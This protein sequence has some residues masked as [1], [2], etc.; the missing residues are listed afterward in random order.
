MT[1]VLLPSLRIALRLPAVR[2]AVVLMVASP[3][4]VAWGGRETQAP[5]RLRVAGM[6]LAAGL[7]MVWDDRCAVVT[8]ATPVGLPAVR[9]GRAAVVLGLLV[10]AW[11]LSCAAVDGQPVAFAA[12]TFQTSALAAV[13][14]ALVGW[15]ARDREG[16]PV[17][18]LPVPALLLAVAAFSQQV[19][20]S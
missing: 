20:W 6:L 1:V 13:L 7:A 18:A 17:L 8:A 15:F 3:A 9:R 4:F 19:S 5:V 11:L 12:V 14:L 16:E 10:P 2:S